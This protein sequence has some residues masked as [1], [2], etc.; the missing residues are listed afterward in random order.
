MMT[1]TYD[2]IVAGGGPAGIFAALELCQEK[3]LKILLIEKG[4]DLRERRCPVRDTGSSCVRCQPCNLVC[5]LGGAGA[6]SDGKL[7]LT[8]QVGGHLEEYLGEEH[9]LAHTALGDAKATLR[10]FLKQLEVHPDL[11]GTVDELHALIFETIPPGSLDPDSKIVWR[12]GKA[13]LNFGK[14][15]GTPLERVDRDYLEWILRKDF[16][17]YIRKIAQDALNGIYPEK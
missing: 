10:V 8:P 12:N 7:V 15:S 14:L 13:V 17:K 9:Y 4:K 11:P 6:F 5:G 2:V 16:N 1:N 3:D